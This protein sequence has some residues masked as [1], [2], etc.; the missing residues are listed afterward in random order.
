MSPEDV[1]AFVT[2]FAGVVAQ[3]PGPGDGSPEIAWGDTF[4][5]YDPGDRESARRMPFA[6][7]VV[8]DYPGFDEASNLDREGVFRVNVG[9][10]RSKVPDAS[11]EV[12]H[13]AFD[14]LLPHPT[15]AKQGWASIVN[16][17]AATDE[18]LHALLA[19]AYER[20]KARYR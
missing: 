15:Y 17:G 2:G 8:K 6:T 11:G 20:A 1:I 10:G 3:T 19:E 5:F 12:D 16:P 14:V 9:V 4:F 18:L 7:I 13:A